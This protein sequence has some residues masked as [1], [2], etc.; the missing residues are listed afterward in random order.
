MSAA[1]RAQG[2][3]CAGR[4]GTGLEREVLVPPVLGREE[5]GDVWLSPSWLVFGGRRAERGLFSVNL[6]GEPGPADPQRPGAV[7]VYRAF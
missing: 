1:V 7:R 4:R 5:A 6:V 3:C 2:C